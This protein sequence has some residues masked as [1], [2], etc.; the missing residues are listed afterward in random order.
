MALLDQH[1]VDR[2]LAG[3]VSTHR[4][5]GILVRANTVENDLLGNTVARWAALTDQ[6]TVLLDTFRATC[7]IRAL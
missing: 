3:Y 2:D 5:H 4:A 7:R 6:A 1:M